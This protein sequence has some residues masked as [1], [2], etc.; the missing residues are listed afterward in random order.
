MFA[1]SKRM[2]FAVAVGV[3]QSR[4]ESARALAGSVAST[5]KSTLPSSPNAETSARARSPFTKP[6]KTFVPTLHEELADVY[7][8]RIAELQANMLK[9]FKKD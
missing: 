4:G 6:M 8:A 3:A 5:F 2:R 1:A 9:D 7:P